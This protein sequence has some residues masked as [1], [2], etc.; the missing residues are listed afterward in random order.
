MKIRVNLWFLFLCL[1]PAFVIAFPLSGIKETTLKNGLKVLTLEEHSAPLISCQIWYRVGS[2]NEK[3]GLTGLSHLLEHMMFKGTKKY[4]PE[5]FSR[6]VQKNGGYDNAF[7]SDDYTAC[8]IN[9]ASDRLEIALDLLSD[10]LG[11]LLL[12]PKE[13]IPEKE[14]VKEERRLHENSPYGRL[15][16]ELDAVSFLV[17]PYRQPTIGWMSDIEAITNEDLRRHYQTYHVPNNATLVIVGDFNTDEIINLTN[18]YFSSIPKGE[19]P[20]SVKEVEPAQRGERRVKIVKEAQ[21]PAFAC[22]YHTVRIGEPDQYVLDVIENLLSGGESSRLYRQLV[23]EKKIALYVSA[24][25]QARKDPSVFYLYAIPQVGHTIEEIEQAVYA[26]LDKLKQEL[27]PE[28]ELQKAK[29]K[30]EADFIFGQKKVHNLG[31]LIGQL[32]TQLSW[33][34]LETYLDKIR[35]VTAEEIQKVAQRYFHQDNRTVA[36]LVLEKDQK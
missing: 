17:H 30:L 19:E 33:K 21:T 20:P 9:L 34:Y 23:Y 22:Q 4:G 35:G 16:E 24:G 5:T 18:K 28:K 8:Y 7:T 15:F 11:N 27:V 10:C 1:F 6:L 12:D 25:S 32:E 29:N 31:F 14:V 13:F 2:R 36:I 26:E 3:P